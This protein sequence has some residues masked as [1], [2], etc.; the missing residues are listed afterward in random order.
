MFF[1]IVEHQRSRRF[2][3]L[4]RGIKIN[5]HL[6]SL[7]L[8]TFHQ[9]DVLRDL[10]QSSQPGQGFEGLSVGGGGRFLLVTPGGRD[11]CWHCLSRKCSPHIKT[12]WRCWGW[13]G[14]WGLWG[15]YLHSSGRPR[16]GLL[17]ADLV[18]GWW[19]DGGDQN[20]REDLALQVVKGQG[21]SQGV[22]G[23]WCG[24]CP[25]GVTVGVEWGGGG[26]RIWP[27]HKGWL[28]G[29]NI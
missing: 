14:R 13:W 9:Y 1:F 8:G 12:S 17:W 6:S 23:C 25:E 28:T 7:Q 26:G 21:G 20:L 15:W 24:R 27:E 5:W 11:Y 4:N 16:T 10:R 19:P 3:R 22:A 18:P 2:R 29:L